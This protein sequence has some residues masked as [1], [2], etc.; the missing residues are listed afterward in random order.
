MKRQTQLAAVVILFICSTMN[1]GEQPQDIDE[2]QIK[3]F[4][5]ST[6]RNVREVYPQVGLEIVEINA[7]EP[8]FTS[9]IG[10]LMQKNLQSHLEQILKT[11]GIRTTNRFN[12]TAANAPLSLNVTVF[13]KVREDTTMPAWAVFI[14]TEAMQ[15]VILTRDMK[16]RSFSRTWPMVPTGPGTRNLLLL[17]PETIEKEIAD[18]VTRQVTNFIIDF[19]A[20]NPAMRITVPKQTQSFQEEPVQLQTEPPT[21]ASPPDVTTN[22]EKDPLQINSKVVINIPF[23][24]GFLGLPYGYGTRYS[25]INFPVE[26]QMGRFRVNLQIGT[27]SDKPGLYVWGPEVSF[28]N[29]IR[30]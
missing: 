8:N 21:P 6:L 13:A 22:Q 17:T 26:F 18:E 10:P 15:P 12:A 23:R 2:L 1:G 24:E 29:I 19:S 20:A 9:Q 14:Y 4:G 30:H 11:S 28:E 7:P 16:I 25:P 27:R 3:W 5:V